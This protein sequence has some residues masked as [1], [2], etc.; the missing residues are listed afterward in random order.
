MPAHSFLISSAQ[1]LPACATAAEPDSSSA[2]SMTNPDRIRATLDFLHRD[3]KMHIRIYP[4]AGF[5]PRHGK[6]TVL[7]RA[8]ILNL[9]DRGCEAFCA[10]CLMKNDRL[11]RGVSLGPI[12][13]SRSAGKISR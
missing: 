8:T 11:A 1:G 3:S 13:D 6:P 4:K 5:S 12:P 9:K 2:V 10:M 7:Q